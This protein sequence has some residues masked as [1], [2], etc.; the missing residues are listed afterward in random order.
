MSNVFAELKRIIVRSG[1]S[2][3]D[4]AEAGFVSRATIDNWLDGRVKEPQLACLLRVAKVFGKS[5]QLSDGE[6]RVVDTPES[7]AA[8]MAGAREFIGLWRRYQ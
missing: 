2:L 8:K 4:I 5:I 7:V 1:M 3:N 6:L